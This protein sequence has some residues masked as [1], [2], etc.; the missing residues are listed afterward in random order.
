MPRHD[1]GQKFKYRHALRHIGEMVRANSVLD[2]GTESN[3]GLRNSTREPNYQ[4]LETG[5]QLKGY[6]FIHVV[7]ISNVFIRNMYV[8]QTVF[9][10]V[11][12]SSI[13]GT[14]ILLVIVS[15]VWFLGSV[16]RRPKGC[17]PGIRA[18]TLSES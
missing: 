13:V 3:F 11:S 6:I 17:P 9:G 16:G 2:F 10:R 14:I 7:F 4:I 15:I 8:T 5:K 18:Q 1:R 12:G